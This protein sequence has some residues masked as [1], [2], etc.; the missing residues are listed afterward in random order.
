MSVF[1]N[2]EDLPAFSIFEELFQ[3]ALNVKWECENIVKTNPGPILQQDLSLLL[4]WPGILMIQLAQ[5]TGDTAYQNSLNELMRMLDYHAGSD[6]IRDYL[7]KI[8]ESKKIPKILLRE[9]QEALTNSDYEGLGDLRKK[10]HRYLPKIIITLLMLLHPKNL[11]FVLNSNLFLLVYSLGN[12][13]VLCCMIIR[14]LKRND[15]DI[16]I[17]KREMDE[18]YLN[19]GLQNQLDI[20]QISRIWPAVLDS[21]INLEINNFTKSNQENNSLEVLIFSKISTPSLRIFF[22]RIF[23]ENAFA[24]IKQFDG[25]T[26]KLG[27]DKDLKGIGY[28]ISRNLGYENDLWKLFSFNNPESNGY[29]F[30]N[31]KNDLQDVLAALVEGLFRCAK[32]SAKAIKSIISSWDSFLKDPYEIIDEKLDKFD[33]WIF[34]FML[35]SYKSR[36]EFFK[37]KSFTRVIGD[38]DTELDYEIINEVR[39]FYKKGKKYHIPS[40]H[41]VKLIEAK[42]ELDHFIKS[43]IKEKKFYD[44]N[45]LVEYF[46]EIR[47][48]YKY[49]SLLEKSDI[50]KI[51]FSTEANA[52][53]NNRRKILSIINTKL[54]G[55]SYNESTLTKLLGLEKGTEEYLKFAE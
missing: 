6:Q 44:E 33:E 43:V 5:I 16:Y 22:N 42:E 37:F 40:E 54:G 51:I 31:E 32:Q 1:E 25:D 7:D 47:P 30:F 11:S 53:R 35:D 13:Y 46:N 38:I 2:S 14:C 4:A 39:D 23:P 26:D 36:D 3:L 48:N 45:E 27:L 52:S 19:C 41:K 50:E 24:Y 10:I 15:G 55:K 12:Y 28:N 9:A 18:A 34:S 17:T 49:I 20:F 8:I 21:I 29:L